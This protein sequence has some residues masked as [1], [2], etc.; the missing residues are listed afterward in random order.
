MNSIIYK[1]KDLAVIIPTK[2]RPVQVKRHLQSL[3]EQQCTLGRV[4]LVAS[5][6]DI[7]DIVM[8]FKNVL[9][10][11][12]HHCDQGQIK[13]RNLGISLLDDST[14]LVA[15]M[16]DDVTYLDDAILKMIEFWNGAQPDTGGVG[17]NISNLPPNNHNYYLNLLGFSASESG[18]VLKSGFNTS[19]SNVEKDVK[20][21]WL[22]GGAT[23]WRQDVLMNNQHK[24]LNLKW[25]VC[26]DLIYSY[27]L[28]KQY[29]LYICSAAK[30]EIEEVV[31]NSEPREFYIDRGRY[32][33]LMGLYFILQNKDL[34]LTG[35]IIKNF[36]Y[37]ISLFV[38]GTLFI[39]TNRY[40]LAIGIIRAFFSSR[41][42]LLGFQSDDLF[43]SKFIDLAN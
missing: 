37:L 16:D 1:I 6:Q 20:V 40:Y 4:I 36:L 3:V 33:Y 25:A 19:I 43:K 10:V 34:S 15:T 12:Y 7:K 14:K 35:F 17:F 38:K 18:R 22:N 31:M 24:E 8:A 11:E 21:E 27:P 41:S 42:F 28:S 32:I 30:V 39:D 29:S 13:Q 23:V 2:D 9:P 26:E 5:G